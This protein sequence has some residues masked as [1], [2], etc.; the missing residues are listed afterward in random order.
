MSV[1]TDI[2]ATYRGP[3]RVIRRIIAAGPRED[4]ALAIL[5]AGCAVVFVAQWPRLARES[6][7]TG[8]DLTM[9]LGGTLM[10]WLLIMPLVF[11][12]LALLSH[13]LLRATGGTGEPFAARMALFWALLA[14]GP[15]ILLWGLMAGFAGSGP[16][17]TVVGVLWCF[18]FLWFWM[19]GLA[20]ARRST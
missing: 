15:L 7:L 5:M 8:G 10:A 19:S 3:R 17:L 12:T 16:G 20:E 2:V 13:W 4:R 11:Y 9:K 18:T 6:H 14:S 1:V